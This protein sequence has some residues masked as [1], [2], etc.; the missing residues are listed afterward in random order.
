[1]HVLS[2]LFIQDKIL[3]NIQ[4]YHIETPIMICPFFLSEYFKFF[5]K[6]ILKKLKV[7]NI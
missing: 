5:V 3:A 2:A 1:M 6:W 7:N 4:S